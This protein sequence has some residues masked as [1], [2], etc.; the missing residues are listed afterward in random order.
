MI[1]KASHGFKVE[2]ESCSESDPLSADESDDVVSPKRWCC[3]TQQKEK[4]ETG[5]PEKYVMSKWSSGY[6]TQNSWW[7]KMNYTFL[8]FFIQETNSLDSR[9]IHVML[10]GMFVICSTAVAS[11]MFCVI[12]WSFFQ[13]AYYI[14]QL[15]T[16]LCNITSK[17]LKI[18]QNEAS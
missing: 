17:V 13:L 9:N 5:Y 3:F 14:F 2:K 7:H 8:N 11:K 12:W 6:A 16:I 15:G 1:F 4:N 18:F 10:Y